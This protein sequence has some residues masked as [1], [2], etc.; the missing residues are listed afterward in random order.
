[1]RH[2]CEFILWNHIFFVFEIFRSIIYEEYFLCALASATT[3]LSYFRH[4]H[5]EKKCNCIEP[6]FAKGTEIYMTCMSLYYFTFEDILILTYM[7]FAI[8]LIWHMEKYN[9]EYIHPWLHIAIA[10]DSH[11]YLSCYNRI[12]NGVEIND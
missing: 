5:H 2:V 9:Y 1:M 10:V 8:L 12:K 4:L 11:Y 7:K 6:F 3:G